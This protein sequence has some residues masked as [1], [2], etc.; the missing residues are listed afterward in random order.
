MK[1]INGF[2][3]FEKGLKTRQGDI[4]EL[5]KMYQIEGTPIFSSCGY[6]MCQNLEDTLRYFDPQ[7]IEICRAEGY[8]EYVEYYDDYTGS[9]KMYSCQK[10]VL[11]QILTPEEIIEEAKKMANFR[12]KKFAAFYPLTE[13]QKAYFTEMYIND[14]WVLGDLIYDFY[15]KTVFKRIS[16]GEKIEE[17]AKQYIKK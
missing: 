13:E 2:K 6:H 12:F 10:I 1:K 5:D 9:G 8:P 11:T 17:I 4:L 14:F 7:L 16:K 3:A 15:D